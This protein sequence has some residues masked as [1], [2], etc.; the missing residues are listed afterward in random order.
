MNEMT[1]YAALDLSVGNKAVTTEKDG[2]ILVVERVFNFSKM[3]F[4]WF[5]SMV[6]NGSGATYFE[7]SWQLG[8]ALEIHGIDYMQD[9]VW[10]P[11]EDI[12]K[13]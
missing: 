5:L 9:K 1:L 2:T 6:I 4:F 12:Y 3:E 10:V 7:A 8:K 11:L 13:S